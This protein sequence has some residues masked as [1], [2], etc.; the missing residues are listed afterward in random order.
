MDVRVESIC[1]RREFAASPEEVWQAF[2]DADALSAWYHPV[3]FST[4]RDRVHVDA[5]V[6]GRWAAAVVVPMDG[7]LH[8]FQGAYRRVEQP[9]VL[10]YSMYYGAGEAPIDEDGPSHTVVVVIEANGGGSRVTYLE[11]GLLP[12]GQSALAQQGM[13]SYFDSLGA[14]LSR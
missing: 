12:V 11:Y 14:Y 7:S 10:E 1:V 9:H 6:G 13:K 2:T 4:P 5:V 3:G 8:R